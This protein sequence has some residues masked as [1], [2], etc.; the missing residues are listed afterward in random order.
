MIRPALVILAAGLGQRYGGLKQLEPVGP[1]GETLLDFTVFDAWRAG[2]VKVVFVVRPETRTVFEGFTASRYGRRIE[3]AFAEQR[4]DDAP[5]G[6]SKPWGT[7]HALLAA[8]D[9]IDGPFGVANAD[10]FYGAQSLAAM[11]AFLREE[12]P[13]GLPTHGLVGFHLGDTLPD[14]GAV[15]RAVCRC[16]PDGWLEQIDEVT[17]I[18]RSGSGG[19][20]TNDAGV[21][22]FLPANTIVSMNL[23]ALRPEVFDLLR[24]DFRR[25]LNDCSALT[26]A[27]W[28]L[29]DVIQNAIRRGQ[30]RVK[31]LRG[32]DVWC[33]ITHA[34][35]RARAA[36]VLR[37]LV[38]R[39]DYPTRLWT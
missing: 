34:R 18:E 23:W 5:P 7:A 26:T 3:V 24:A 10:D 37:Q 30:A 20:F 1:A 16:G 29:P 31:V 15:A 35:D 13:A 11:A 17:G 28:Y 9:A 12:Q 22:S 8:A 19:R 6:R 36:E 38:A 27:E 21:T 32:G 4:L 39:G 14:E 2:V 25:F 33:G